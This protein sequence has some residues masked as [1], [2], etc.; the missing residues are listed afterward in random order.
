MNAVP[1]YALEGPRPLT[2]CFLSFQLQIIPDIVTIKKV[3]HM[4]RHFIV[5]NVLSIK[6]TIFSHFLVVAIV[7]KK[8][9]RKG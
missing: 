9:L 2:S 7:S 4:I 6:V 1:D 8:Y 5:D 3:K